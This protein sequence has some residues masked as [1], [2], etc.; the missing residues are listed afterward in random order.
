MK[1]I[2]NKIARLNRK[3]S[4][5]FYLNLFNVFFLLAV[6]VWAARQADT[7]G[8][9]VLLLYLAINLILALFLLFSKVKPIKIKNEAPE[10]YYREQIDRTITAN[11]LAQIIFFIPVALSSLGIWAIEFTHDNKPVVWIYIVISIIWLLAQFIW[12]K[13]RKFL[14]KEYKNIHRTDFLSFF[15]F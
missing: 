15:H 11:D 2:E 10:K 13:M 8:E 1:D 6:A 7:E 14:R 5:I 4:K 9:M 3:K 12:F